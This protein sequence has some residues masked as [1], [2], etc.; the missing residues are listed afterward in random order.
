MMRLVRRLNVEED[1]TVVMVIHDLDLALRYS[2]RLVV[3]RD[4]SV[5]AAGEVDEGTRRRRSTRPSM[6]RFARVLPTVAG[7][8]PCFHEMNGFA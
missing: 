2:D 3:M 4:G 5:L 7:R 1:K 6:W 8:F